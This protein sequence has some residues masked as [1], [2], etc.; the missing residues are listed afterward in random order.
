[1][2]ALPKATTTTKNQENNEENQ[3]EH[4]ECKNI[5]VEMKKKVNRR[6]RR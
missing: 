1:M 6:V 2:T 4:L 3:E 5:A